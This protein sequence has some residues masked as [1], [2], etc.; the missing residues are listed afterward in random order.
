MTIISLSVGR[1]GNT[2]D[3]TYILSIIY[4]LNEYYFYERGGISGLCN[5]VSRTAFHKVDP[6]KFEAIEHRGLY[7][8]CLTKEH[9]CSCAILTNKEYPLRVIHH[10]LTKIIEDYKYKYGDLWKITK[11]DN[12]FK[13]DSLNDYIKQ[14]QD[15]KNVDKISNIKY[16]LEDTKDIIMK[17]IDKVL[18]RGEQLDDLIEKTN[19]LSK[20]SK[21]FYKTTKKL[22]RCCIIL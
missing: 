17:S 8:Y 18:A 13:L 7:I 3:E 16:Q 12:E 22:N 6:V 4:N 14:Y 19:D 11:K 5:F 20:S 15:P 9:L 1:R 21:R 10:L 2:I